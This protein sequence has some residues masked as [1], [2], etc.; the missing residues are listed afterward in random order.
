MRLG[1]E[2][3]NCDVLN[4]VQADKRYVYNTVRIRID[5]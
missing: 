4:I 3:C 5:I 2:K 1:I